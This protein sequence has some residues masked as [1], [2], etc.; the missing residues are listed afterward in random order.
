I[1][2][3]VGVCAEPVLG[4]KVANAEA[5]HEAMYKVTLALMVKAG[6][7]SL[8]DEA[9]VDVGEDG[10]GIGGFSVGAGVGVGVGVGVEAI[11]VG[12]GGSGSGRGSGSVGMERLVADERFTAVGSGKSGILGG[13]SNVLGGG[14]VRDVGRT[15][16][17]LGGGRQERQSSSVFGSWPQRPRPDSG[18]AW[19]KEHFILMD[20][21]QNQDYR[22]AEVFTEQHF[23]V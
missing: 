6:A 19:K 15:S 17:V 5:I 12:A 13:S 21:L 2:L 9:E 1:L 7:V 18:E 4:K 22:L 14:G 3:D 23:L 20:K 11:G 16:N 10:I 8:M